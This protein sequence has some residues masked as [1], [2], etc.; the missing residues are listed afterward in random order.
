MNKNTVHANIGDDAVK[1]KTGKVWDDWFTILDKAGAKKMTHTE[2]ATHLY[3]KCGVPGWWCQMV[4]VG[5]ERARGLR[6]KYET[7]AGYSISRSKTIAVS[8]KTLY[9]AW[10]NAKVRA[11]W[12]RENKVEIRKA[13]PGKSMRLTWKDGKTLLSVNFYPRSEGKSQIV[14]EHNKLATATE[15]KK[16]Q[17]YW[18]RKLDILKSTL[19]R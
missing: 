10:K 8:V 19:E 11:G 17:T 14:V 2:I 3:D 7:P 5:Y 18:E 9:N 4:A 6:G 15:A 1:A 12:L 13:T 16:M